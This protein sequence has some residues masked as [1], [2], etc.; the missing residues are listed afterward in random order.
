[1]SGVKMTL[2]GHLLPYVQHVEWEDKW[3]HWA[4]N[5]RLSYPRRG[6]TLGPCLWSRCE[7]SVPGVRT[8]WSWTSPEGK[9][10]RTLTQGSR[11]ALDFLFVQ[12]REVH[13]TETERV[14]RPIDPGLGEST[15]T[16]RD[17][18][19]WIQTWNGLNRVYGRFRDI[20]RLE[21]PLRGQSSL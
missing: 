19:P 13:S 6:R 21:T 14:R 11:D 20:G 2:S 1:M 16:P 18:Y 8:P 17:P 3:T 10:L 7:G 4:G 5:K 9:G 12:G 15:S